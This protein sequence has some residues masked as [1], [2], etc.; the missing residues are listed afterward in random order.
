[1]I[2]IASPFDFTKALTAGLGPMYVASMAPA[3]LELIDV[4]GRRVN[5]LGMA[6]EVAQDRPAVGRI[7]AVAHDPP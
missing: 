1:M 5:R 6:G 3:K 2:R 7:V 4:A